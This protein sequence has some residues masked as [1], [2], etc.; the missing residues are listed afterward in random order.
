MRLGLGG[1]HRRSPRALVEL[2]EAA[3]PRQRTDWSDRSPGEDGFRPWVQS[4][5]P[6][7]V[8]AVRAAIEAVGLPSARTM[9]DKLERDMP[10][11]E[12]AKALMGWNRDRIEKSFRRHRLIAIIGYGLLPLSGGDE[13]LLDRY[14]NL[15][16]SARE[17]QKFGSDRRQS[18]GAAVQLSLANLAQVAGF[19]DVTAMVWELEAKIGADLGPAGRTWQAGE[20]TLQVVLDGVDAGVEVRRAGRSL[21]SVPAAV[22]STPSYVEAREAVE[23]VRDQARRFRADVVERLVATG[24]L[25]VVDH[26]DRLLRVPV[27]R[28]LLRLVVFRQADGTMGLLE[29]GA[30]LAL[31][32]LDGIAHAVRGPLGLAHSH[33]LLAAGTLGGW[34]REVVRRRLVQPV[35]QVFRELYVVTPAERGETSSHRFEGQPLNSAVAGRLLTTRGWWVGGRDG[36]PLEVVRDFAGVRAVLALHGP[37]YLGEDCP[38]TTGEIA[39]LAPAAPSGRCEEPSGRLLLEQVPPLA[40]SEA[41]RDT[42]LVVSVAGIGGDRDMSST[43]LMGGRGELVTALARDMGLNGVTVDGKFVRVVGSLATYRVHLG[44]AVV[45]VEPGNHVCIVPAAATEATPLFLPF[46]D[47]DAR[48]REVVSKVLLLARDSLITDPTI[49]RQIQQCRSDKADE[50]EDHRHSP[51]L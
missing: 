9:L 23:G 25:F 14:S 17:A 19:H 12:L 4:T 3:V 33:H 2:V 10:G 40:F 34:Q 47:S 43:E 49:L 37:R 15:R 48:T 5:A 31:R 11:A 42:D 45:H 41:M 46:A 32:D 20:Y 36:E 8:A 16:R 38:T 28:E 39:F 18:H 1:D 21:R 35:K 44:S 7:D 51:S 30:A 26:L 13:E 24:E 6:L 27:G 50:R 22:R 29:T